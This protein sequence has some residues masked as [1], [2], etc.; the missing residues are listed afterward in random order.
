MSSILKNLSVVILLIATLAFGYFLYVQN[1]NALLDT[2][3]GSLSMD[4]SAEAALFL[5]RLNEMK[6]ITLSND[7]FLDP[8]FNAFVDYPGDVIPEPTGKANPFIE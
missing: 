2:Q 7:I 8:R 1:G 5:Q 3:E 6:A 4:V